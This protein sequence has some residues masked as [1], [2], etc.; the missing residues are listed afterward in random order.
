MLC[1]TAAASFA[2]FSVAA[3]VAADMGLTAGD[4]ERNEVFEV[5][6]NGADVRRFFAGGAMAALPQGNFK[7]PF[8]NGKD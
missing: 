6:G 5:L 8:P 7:P 1:C 4:E 3:I 2:A